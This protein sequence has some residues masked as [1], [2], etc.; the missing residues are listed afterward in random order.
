MKRASGGDSVVV[1]SVF[2]WTGK[3]QIVFI[4]HRMNSAGYFNMLP[5]SLLPHLHNLAVNPVTIQLDNAPIYRSHATQTW[6][7]AHMNFYPD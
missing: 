6:L 3:C 1:R 2:G 7:A 4:E 5:Q